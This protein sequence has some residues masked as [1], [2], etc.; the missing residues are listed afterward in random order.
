[1]TIYGYVRLC[2]TLYDLNE[3][4]MSTPKNPSDIKRMLPV[5]VFEDEEDDYKDHRENDE[6]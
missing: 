1:M 4:T 3:N 2:L 6:L 5:T